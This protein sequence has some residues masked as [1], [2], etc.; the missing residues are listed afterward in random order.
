M[1]CE[2]LFVLCCVLNINSETWLLTLKF[3]YMS[4]TIF[5]DYTFGCPDPTQ[6]TCVGTCDKKEDEKCDIPPCCRIKDIT[7]LTTNNIN[8]GGYKNIR[9]SYHYYSNDKPCA[10]KI[11]RNNGNLQ[12]FYRDLIQDKNQHP[13]DTGILTGLQDRINVQ[14]QFITPD[15]GDCR[16]DSVRMYGDI[17]TQDPTKMPTE[18]PTD[19]PTLL[20][21]DTPSLIPTKS[22]ILPS[23]NPTDI[24]SDIPSNIPTNDPSMTPTNIPTDTP[25]IPPTYDPTNIPTLWTMEPIINP[26][27]FESH[28][29]TSNPTINPTFYPTL[30]P[31]INP[32]VDA[33]TNTSNTQA[34]L[35][36]LAVFGSVLTILCIIFM[37]IFF[38][39]KNVN[40]IQEDIITMRVN[41]K[42]KEIEMQSS[43]QRLMSTSSINGEF[44][45]TNHNARVIGFSNE[46]AEGGIQDTNDFMDMGT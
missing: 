35:T 32:G 12:V 20:P 44:D 4:E 37:V 39:K 3:E 22:T 34:L 21:S 9:V 6:W 15:G 41:E 42:L 13:E 18:T 27:I 45:E 36:I 30:N 17:M 28:P 16:V 2:C 1:L 26:T 10:I 46:L 33:A 11:T 38:K 14:I 40:K 23:I 25:S 5:E 31:A 19:T 8:A 29:P 24:P 43:P 7:T